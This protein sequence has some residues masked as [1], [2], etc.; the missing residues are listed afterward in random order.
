MLYH[1]V[2][3]FL[4]LCKN[5][6]SFFILS[7]VCLICAFVCFLFLQGKGYA[8]YQITAEQYAETQRL[9]ISCQDSEK[10]WKIYD[11]LLNNPALPTFK[12]ATI[13]NDECSGV[14][15]DFAYNDSVWYTPYGRF[16]SDKEMQTGENVLML[17]M[18]YISSL[19]KY[20]IEHLWDQELLIHGQRFLPIANFQDWS[21][22]PVLEE[23]YQTE[24]FPTSIIMPIK[25][26][27]NAGFQATKLRIIFA[28]SLS[29]EQIQLLRNVIDSHLN[30]PDTV[31]Y[32]LLP[33]TKNE[34][35]LRSY[36][37]V[38]FQYGLI[39]ILALISSI[40]IIMFW[41]YMEFRR[42]KVY[43]VCGA[44]KNQIILL[45]SM[46]TILLV[47]ITYVIALSITALITHLTPKGIASLLP[48]PI[49]GGI[50]ASVVLFM[51]VLVN[52]RALPI[53]L[54]KKFLLK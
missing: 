36:L 35:A 47:T 42:Y 20:Q 44:T 25:A 7:A 45:L 5:N 31:N 24:T 11:E 38:T 48:T 21:E 16:F 1:A 54:S 10:I 15:W 28:E 40:S 39:L 32:Y 30:D 46:N 26:F 3:N 8:S 18:K 27:R 14:L 51:L 9:F 53:L 22:N 6:A 4:K 12:T 37:A 13:S 50:Y 29:Y 33:H 52:L 49:Y 41:L 23:T 17:G 2:K 19:S 43:L 34:K